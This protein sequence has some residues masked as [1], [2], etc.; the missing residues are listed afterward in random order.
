VFDET[1]AMIHV[2]T[3]AVEGRK[4]RCA[5]PT[6]YFCKFENVF[7]Q[8]SI[9]AQVLSRKPTLP[10][11]P[12]T[13]REID[14]LRLLAQGLS[15]HEISEHSRIALST[16]KWHLKNVF[17]KLDVSSRTGAIARAREMRLIE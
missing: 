8:P 14:M 5:L 2:I 10:L 11:E 9:A 1:P 16:A 3:A 7:T 12:L 17:A 4:L 15:N 13:E 6:H